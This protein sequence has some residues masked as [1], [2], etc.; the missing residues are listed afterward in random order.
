MS[1]L[2]SIGASGIKAYGAALATV[3]DNIAN[4][5]TPGYARRA[6]RTSEPTPGRDMI[7]Y[8][9][10]ATPGGT[11]IAGISRAVNDFLIEDSRLAE[12]AAGRTGARLEWLNAAERAVASPDGAVRPSVTAVFAAADRL[13][14]DPTN[15]ALRGQFLGAVDQAATRIRTAANDLATISAGIG[16]D[17]RQTATAVS[18]DLA[19][20][21]GVNRGLLR[22]REGSTNEAGL[23]DERDRILDRL[24]AA[25][26]IAVDYGQ[27]G[28]VTV[29]A[30]PGGETLLAGTTAARIDASVQPDGTLAFL[31]DGAAFIPGGARLGGL[32]A[33]AQDV[34]GKRTELDGLATGLAGSLNA[35]HQSGQDLDGAAGQPLLATATGRAA[36]LVALLSDP[37]ALAAAGSGTANGTMLAFGTLQASGIE[38]GWA[39]LESDV[40]LLSATAASENSAASLRREGAAAARGDISAVDLDREA[41]DLLRFQQAYQA[42][43]R[44][45]EVARDVIQTI[46]NAV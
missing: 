34:A 33:A 45:I 8:R 22:A 26:P 9:G 37:R 35:V 36:D 43:A 40:V 10:M 18:T 29:R 2:L 31:L 20:L 42:S 17:A 38:T 39:R 24:S 25:L 28:T 46:L 11:L 6:V 16:D 12:S 19:A 27:R 41:A 7:L 21:E 4:A 1:D 3:S 5:Q 15:L 44:V 14:A 32:A 30:T 13:T 23:L